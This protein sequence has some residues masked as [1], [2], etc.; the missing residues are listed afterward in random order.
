M[1]ERHDLPCPHR[2]HH[3]VCGHCRA[4]RRWHRFKVLVFSSLFWASLLGAV[5][6]LLVVPAVLAYVFYPFSAPDAQ[7][8]FFIPAGLSFLVGVAAVGVLMVSSNLDYREFRREEQR[9]R[10]R[11]G[12]PMF[13]ELGEGAG[14]VSRRARKM[15]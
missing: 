4:S 11:R 8:R 6:F 13:P 3:S 5:A 2:S 14:W 1:S 9:E 7:S 15:R 10:L 12:L